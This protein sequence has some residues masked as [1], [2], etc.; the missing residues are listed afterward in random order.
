MTECTAKA[1]EFS[2][3]DKRR[4]HADFDGG[5][6]TSDAGGLLLREAD[7]RLNLVRRLSACIAD[8]REPSMIV[9]EQETMLR[10]RILAIALG[11]EDLNDHQTLR[12][13]PALRLM[14]GGERDALASAPTLCRLENRVD[15]RAMWRMAEVIV[16]TFIAS[17]R[18]P[19]K[20]LV[21]DIDA[22][23]DRVHGKQEGRFFHGYYDSYC[24][25]P[26]YIFSGEQ[27]LGAYLRPSNIDAARHA[28]PILALLVRKLRSVPGWGGVRIV[29]RAD[30]GF[31]RWRMLR[32]C[33]RHDVKYIIG[34]ARNTRLAQQADP[35]IQ[36]A[37]A[38]FERLKTTQRV[39]GEVEYAAYSWDKP[40]RVIVKAEHL[41]GSSEGT[42]GGG[43]K[44]NMRFVVTN[45]TGNAGHLYQEVYCAR[46]EMENRVKEQQMGLFA[47]RTS[48]HR[49][50]ANQFRVLL[51]AAAYV[52]VEH[53]RRVALAGTELARA[54]VTRIRLDLFKIGARVKESVRRIVLH[55]ASACPFK[56][57]FTLAAGRLLAP[58]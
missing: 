42:P 11:Y 57:V 58:G 32:W 8:P 15:R 10:Q 18:E 39:M 55:L 6:I 48:C 45:L 54:Q 34:L 12:S 51:S 22:T 19:P 24:F 28:W 13:D 9:H 21:L 1:V 17:H 40:R 37:R 46:G 2:A 44:A 41:A 52:L 14:A 50:M 27:L 47:D 31:C 7:R 26:L 49:F 43:D 29:V 56:E 25:L 35:L 16:D 33:E 38:D 5:A 53:I 3:H 20:E 36:Q 4:V 30:S 23:D